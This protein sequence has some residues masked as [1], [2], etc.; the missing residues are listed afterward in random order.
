[1]ASTIITAVASVI[2]FTLMVFS[3]ELGHFIAAKKAGVEVEE[4]SIGMGPKVISWGR[5]E[6]KYSIRIFP[7]GA[8]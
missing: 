5:K 6:T 7:I 1:M 4:F 3:H 2:I 8:M